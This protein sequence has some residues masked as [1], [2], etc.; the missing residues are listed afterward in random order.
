MRHRAGEQ[1]E[2]PFSAPFLIALAGLFVLSLAAACLWIF[3][4]NS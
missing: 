4:A 1:D 2:D 3:V